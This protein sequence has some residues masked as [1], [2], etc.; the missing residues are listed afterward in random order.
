MAD[1][2]S[3]GRTP[4]PILPRPSYVRMS[5]PCPLT[6][7]RTSGRR[8]PVQ[9]VA[10]PKARR[11]LPMAS[12][13]GIGTARGINRCVSGETDHDGV[14]AVAGDRVHTPFSRRYGDGS[15][16]RQRASSPGPRR[17]PAGTVAR[18]AKPVSLPA[19]RSS[20]VEPR[21]TTSIRPRPPDGSSARHSQPL[22]VEGQQPGQDRVLGLPPGQG[23]PSRTRSGR[24]GRGPRGRE[25]ARWERQ[26]IVSRAGRRPR[27]QSR[28]EAEDWESESEC[29]IATET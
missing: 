5:V 14:N 19:T 15:G 8:M 23:R 20:H 18:A 9:R 4:A 27:E 3:G 6:S 16:A 10:S 17:T 22:E 11:P 28:R 29:P 13:P 12:S 21:Q 25:R 2:C 26:P 7:R 1:T 24:R